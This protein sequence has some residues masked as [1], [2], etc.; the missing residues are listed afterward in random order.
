MRVVGDV[1]CLPHF[2]RGVNARGIGRDPVG[3][4]GRLGDLGKIGKRLGGEL[5]PDREHIISERVLF[6]ES[7]LFID[8][9]LQSS[10]GW[11]RSSR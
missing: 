5:H 8:S 2:A 9:S 3:I 11:R 6:M 1:V 4:L 10:P 7:S